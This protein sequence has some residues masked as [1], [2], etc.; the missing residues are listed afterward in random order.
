MYEFVGIC[1]RKTD[2]Y[3]ALGICGLMKQ[4]ILSIF[5]WPHCTFSTFT[6]TLRLTFVTPPPKNSTPPLPPPSSFNFILCGFSQLRFS[7][8]WFWF[9]CIC[10]MNVICMLRG[11]PYHENGCVV[12]VCV[13]S[14]MGTCVLCILSTCKWHVFFL[15]FNEQTNTGCCVWRPHCTNTLFFLCDVSVRLCA[16]MCGRIAPLCAVRVGQL[17]ADHASFSLP[18]SLGNRS[19]MHRLQEWK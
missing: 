19:A 5:G 13:C 3:P 16:S 14:C 12:C 1:T 9:V 11:R 15:F 18:T 6:T 10:I 17:S 8:G 7:D 4:L 2:F